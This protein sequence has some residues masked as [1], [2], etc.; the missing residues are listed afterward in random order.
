MIRKMLV[1]AA[2]V[3]MPAAA[4]AGIAGGGVAS[5]K[6]LGPPATGSCA[7]SGAVTFAKPGITYGGTI[8]NKTSEKSSSAITPASTSICGTKTIKDKIPSNTTQCWS[9]LPTYSKTAPVG[10]VLVSGAAPSCDVGGASAASDSNIVAADVKTALKDQ[11]YYDNAAGF[12]SGGTTSIVAALAGGVPVT[13]NGNAGTI[14]VTG[15]SAITGSGSSLQCGAGVVGFEI[16][17]TTTF[18]GAGHA[19]IDICLSSDT[20][21][22]TTGN[23]END[24]LGGSATIVTG[25]IGGAS[26][27]TYT[28]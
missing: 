4:L 7:I 14:T 27:I 11:F 21:T 3:A 25:V 16:D 22:G 10:G 9:T 15:S 1:I 5:A 19:V 20:G 12:V 13:N 24:L 17:G 2:A 23:F 18:A 28:P 26:N 6:V 8:T